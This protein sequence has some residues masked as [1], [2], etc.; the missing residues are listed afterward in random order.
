MTPNTMTP[1]TFADVQKIPI[2]YKPQPWPSPFRLRPEH[3]AELESLMN[4]LESEANL[5][6]VID[7][8]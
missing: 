2:N 5:A 8:A 6:V 7:R 1:I 3:M 4:K